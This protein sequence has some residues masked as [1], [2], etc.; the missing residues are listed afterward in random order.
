[1]RKVYSLIIFA[2][3]LAGCATTPNSFVEPKNLTN[4]NSA[5]VTI[6]RTNVK[7]H[8]SNPEKPFFYVDDLYV[9]KLGTGESISFKLL[10]GE[11]S[12]SYKESVFF[13]PLRESGK[14]KGV[15]KAGERYYFRYSKEFRSF[16]PT[17]TGIST[18]DSTTF[19]PATEEEFNEKK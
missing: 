16:V 14:T 19:Q 6:Y 7:Y 17:G 15:F 1:M 5:I 12:L 4:E 10:P 3:L 8:S 11:H 18:S 13:M 9:G 2:Q